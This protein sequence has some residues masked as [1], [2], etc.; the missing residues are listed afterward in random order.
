MNVSARHINMIPEKKNVKSVIT[1]VNSVTTLILIVQF[2]L[3][4][5]IWP[6][7]THVNVK[8]LI[9]KMEIPSVLYAIGIAKHAL[10]KTLLI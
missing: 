9:M 10:S 3:N 4:Q 2:V 7:S 1:F 8:K 6:L 5:D